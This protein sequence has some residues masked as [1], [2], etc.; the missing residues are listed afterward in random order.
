MAKSYVSVGVE[1]YPVCGAEHSEVVLLDTRMRDSMEQKTC[2]GRSPCQEHAARIAKGYTYMLEYT[3]E[4]GA[5]TGR[6][7]EMPPGMWESVISQPRPP[8]GIAVT[9]AAGFAKLCGGGKA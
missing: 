6:Y 1:I 8:G 7:A 3:R 2:V 4:G 9:D 5:P